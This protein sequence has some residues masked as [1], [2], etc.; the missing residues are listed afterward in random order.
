MENYK[1]LLKKVKVYGLTN[2]KEAYIIRD[3]LKRSVVTYEW[4]QVDH[5]ASLSHIDFTG[6]DLKFPVVELPCGTYLFNP[7]IEEIA[8]KLGWIT[9]PVYKEYDVSIFGGGPAGLSAAVYAASE[10]LKT[11]LIER[12]AIGGQAGTSSLI[13]NYLGFPGGIT[14]T[15][16]AERAR[17]QAVKFGVEILLLRK[18]HHTEFIDHKIHV[19]LIDGSIIIAKSNICAT[20]VEYRRSEIPNE[21]KFLNAGVYYGAGASE[22]HLCKNKHVFVVG[23]GNSAGQ[24]VLNFSKHAEKVSMIIRGSD[25]SSSLSFYLINRI[26]K[27]KNV[28]VIFNAKIT[29]LEGKGLLQEIEVTDTFFNTSKRYATNFVFSCIGGIPNTEWAKN[30]AIIRDE[31]GYLIT[32]TDLWNPGKPAV[33]K[34]DR[35]PAFLETS[36]P[37]CFAAGDVRH[38]SIKRVASAVGEGAMAVTMVHRYLQE[39]Y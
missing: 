38:N 1:G 5:A 26:L 11:V 27:R 10:G 17:Q 39:T 18:G 25:L 9:K 19:E 22:A 15:D 23:G 12:E 24:A 2:S 31:L 29:A 6:K 35:L 28:E 36:V 13:E 16:L 7:T 4:I 32:G 33:W 37:G 21:K 14:G 3:F 8:C 34:P 20:G 30:T